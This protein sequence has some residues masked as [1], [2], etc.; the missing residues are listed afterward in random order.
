MNISHAHAQ[1]R[2]ADTTEGNG[3]EVIEVRGFKNSLR[4]SMLNKKASAVVSDGI[5]AEDL[6]KF[7]DQ[8]VAESLQRITG[9]AIDR[10]GGEGQFITVRGFGPQFNTVLVNGRQIATENQGR[11]FSFDTLPAELISGA[12][13]YKSPIASLQEGGIGATV[14]VT[15]ASP[16][17]FD[18]FAGAASAK[19]MYEEISEEVTPQVSG[20]VSNRFLDGKLGVL[21]AGSYQERKAQTNMLQTSYW[22]P[23]ISLT[24]R[25]ELDNPAYSESAQFNGVYV[26]QNFDQTVDFAHRQRTSGNVVVQYAPQDNMMLKLDALYSK[27]EVASNATGVGHWLSDSNL[28]NLEF[29]ENGSLVSLDSTLVEGVGGAT[30]FIR[31]SFSRDVDIQAYG[32]N[33]DWAINDYFTANFDV[34]TSTAKNNSGGA[35]NFN[36]VGYN[37]SYSLDYSGNI[38]ELTIDGGSDALVDKAAGRMHVTNREGFD[39]EDTIDEYRADF[40]WLPDSDNAFSK[41]EFGVYYQDRQKQNNSISASLC[42]IYCGYQYDIPDELLSVFTPQNFFAQASQQWITYDPE[43]YFDYAIS[44]EAVQQIAGATGQTVEEVQALLDEESINNPSLGSNSFGVKEEVLSVYS[45]MYFSFMLSDMPVDVNFGLRF[46]QTDTSVSGFGRELLD[47]EPIPN[48]PS[49]YNAVYA[50]D[51]GVPVSESNSYTNLLPN[52]NARLELTE[53]LMLR[54]GYSETLTR[55]T[56]S[57]LVPVFNVSVTR[58]GNLQAE[59]GN[60]NLKPFL[61]T[62]MDISF[63]WYY[64]DT[65]YFAV[66][67]FTKEV[68]D[69][70]VATVESQTLNLQSGPYD[71]TVRLPGNGE[72]AD[73]NGLEIAWLHT[74]DNGFG[75]QAN[76]TVVNSDA[77]LDSSDTSE[78]FALEGLGDSQN[79]VLFYEQG[80]LQA[81]VAY[82]N[83][84]GFMQDLVS[85]LGGTEP[86]FTE[87]YGQLDVSASYDINETL[88][89]FLEGI[90]VTGETLRRHGR[91]QEQFVQLIDD[92]ARYTFGVRASF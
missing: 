69:F 27:F 21:V 6:G 60:A 64:A 9:V 20:L 79:L 1:Q 23:N 75:I 14:N 50:T 71:F 16:F 89:V 59:S 76:A 33:F 12:N 39:V 57:D 3:Y 51:T 35:N 22:R 15:T 54:L 30:D 55:P 17:D 8:N 74:F 92:G 42:S 36:V 70:I 45:Q 43:A 48:D 34:S 53:D 67:A 77:T 5:S 82:N 41:M 2:S 29:S 62:N 84:E 66:A 65:S 88:T 73:V 37:N 83:R 24:N 26:P 78:V 40:T 49:D 32:I 90:N 19:G 80:P 7:P 25:S 56:M 68:E 4:E 85:P 72:T 13:V 46:S 63:E 28:D 38:P 86:R 47:I 87:T 58:P 44:D 10:S 81:R 11:E 52:V 18:G 31:Q 61:S 91:Y